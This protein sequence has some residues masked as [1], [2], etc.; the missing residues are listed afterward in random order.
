MKTLLIGSGASY[1]ILGKDAPLCKGFGEVFDK[2]NLKSQYPTLYTA[3]AFLRK[4]DK[5]IGSCWAL[6]KVWN[7]IDENAKLCNILANGEIDWIQ[8]GWEIKKAV[9]EI[10]GLSL[11]NQ[12]SSLMSN[13]PDN[14]FLKLKDQI[15]SLQTND[16]FVTTNYDLMLEKICTA[17]GWNGSINC[18][19]ESEAD[20]RRQTPILFKLHGSLDWI[21]RGGNTFFR[22]SDGNPWESSTFTTRGSDSSSETR[23]CIIGPVR[24]KDEMIF[25]GCQPSRLTQIFNFQWKSFME[26]LK[27]SS[28]LIVMGYGFPEEDVYG[29]RIL[30]EGIRLRGESAPLSIS[31]FLKKEDAER[32]KTNL[33][34]LFPENKVDIQSREPI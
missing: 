19:D 22:T 21:F 3:I 30:Q 15:S 33:S 11:N 32:T 7:G 31:L 5:S 14:H 10:Y 18:M 8:A 23:P 20:S 12:L 25:Q 28:E 34:K 2:L 16:V 27:N 17:L 13:S 9:N 1:A 29:N 4:Q 26:G 24:F 6:D